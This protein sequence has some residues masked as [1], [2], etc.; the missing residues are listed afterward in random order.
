[1]WD[2][3]TI[4]AVTGAVS[5]GIG[6]L[7]GVVL[8]KGV[9]AIIKLRKSKQ[10]GIMEERKYEDSQAKD[11]YHQATTAYEKLLLQFEVRVTVLESA[12]RTINEELKNTRAELKASRDEHAN[13]M[14]AQETLRGE[15]K[16]LQIHVNRL[17]THD[18]NNKENVK[19]IE[20][21]IE[22]IVAAK[23]QP[24]AK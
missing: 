4:I 24:E 10:E 5:G 8:T 13:C 23:P 18:Q 12:N 22:E 7:L 20:Q 1:M 2:T 19:K 16:A 15:L 14:V 9:D 3:T 17:W 21:H 11:A 6:G